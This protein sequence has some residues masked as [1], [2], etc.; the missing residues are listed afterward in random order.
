MRGSEI[1]IIKSMLSIKIIDLAKSLSSIFKFKKKIKVIGLSRGEKLHETLATN[2]EL[3]YL[4]IYKDL[5]I[6]N[7]NS[8][9]KYKLINANSMRVFL[10]S[11]S[12]Y[13]SKINKI[14]EFINSN[15]LIK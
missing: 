5:I 15:F 12:S 7:K 9:N 8:N 1:F 14:I 6:I 4:S 13:H 11:D 2:D 10:S 3:K